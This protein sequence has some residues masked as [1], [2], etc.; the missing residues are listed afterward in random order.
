MW[1]Q[2]LVTGST[3]TSQKT[4][5]VTVALSGNLGEKD[6]VVIAISTDLLIASPDYLQQQVES[7]LHERN[8]TAAA[9][10]VLAAVKTGVAFVLDES[11]PIGTAARMV[12]PSD[13]EY[14]DVV[15][16]VV[17]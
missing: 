9:N 13:P 5:D 17:V 2:G 10:V 16:A 1:T 8:R 15:L 11:L 6:T 14:A 7:A 12:E 4:A 3:V